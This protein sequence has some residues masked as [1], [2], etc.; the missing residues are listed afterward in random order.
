MSIKHKYQYYQSWPICDTGIR[1]CSI[2][3]VEK[4]I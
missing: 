2:T 4:T 1:K 3:N